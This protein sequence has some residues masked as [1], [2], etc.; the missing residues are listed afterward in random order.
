MKSYILKYVHCWIY[1]DFLFNKE[2]K[3]TEKLSKTILDPIYPNVFTTSKDQS[4]HFFFNS[5]K[6][7]S[8]KS[9]LK[10]V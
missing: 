9:P 10:R 6:F 3:S 2:Q 1:L 7:L 8:L 4:F 5:S